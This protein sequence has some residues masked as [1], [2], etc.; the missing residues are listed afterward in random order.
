MEFWT[1]KVRFYEKGLVNVVNKKP[2]TKLLLVL[3]TSNINS[4]KR[5]IFLL[6]QMIGNGSDFRVFRE[7]LQIRGWNAVRNQPGFDKLCV[8]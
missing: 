4:S 8:L 3:A 5:L 2:F 1:K 7:I 6:Y